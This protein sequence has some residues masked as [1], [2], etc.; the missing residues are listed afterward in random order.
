MKNIEP[1]QRRNSQQVS[2]LKRFI[3]ILENE[4]RS[5]GLVRGSVSRHR[6]QHDGQT[7]APDMSPPFLTGSL[8][9]RAAAGGATSAALPHALCGTPRL[10]RA[11]GWPPELTA[12]RGCLHLPQHWS[13]YTQVRRCGFGPLGGK[14]VP[15]LSWDWINKT[16]MSFYPRVPTGCPWAGF[17]YCQ[18]CLALLALSVVLKNN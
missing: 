4:A 7:Q 8:L 2:K 12:R 17:L 11:A 3:A 13:A 18:V 6:G 15:R 10:G 5:L 9:H 1:R 14:T 16:C